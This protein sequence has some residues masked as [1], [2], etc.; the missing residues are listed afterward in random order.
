MFYFSKNDLFVIDYDLYDPKETHQGQGMIE[1]YNEVNSKGE[2][3]LELE[4]HS[5]C[6]KLEPGQSLTAKVQ[7]SLIKYEGSTE[8]E[9]QIEFINKKYFNRNYNN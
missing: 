2:G 8:Q 5:P 6:K 1:L 3:L 4:Y 9:E 7:W